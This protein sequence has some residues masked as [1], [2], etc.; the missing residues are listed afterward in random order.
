MD[1]IGYANETSNTMIVELR[2]HP[3]VLNAE[4]REIH[5][6]FMAPWS[7]SPDMTLK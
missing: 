5:S 3:V 2:T 4:K 7:N 1:Y 6:F